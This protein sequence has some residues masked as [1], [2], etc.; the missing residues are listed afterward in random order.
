MASAASCE[1]PANS[2]AVALR[3]LG[4]MYS[5]RSSYDASYSCYGAAFAARSSVA[6]A[7]SA[8]LSYK[9]SLADPVAALRFSVV[10]I[11]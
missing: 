9:I 7:A 1:I 11:S 6:A 5:Y 2:N 8:R 4:G 10:L 3:F